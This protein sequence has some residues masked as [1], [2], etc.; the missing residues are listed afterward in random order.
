MQP[1]KKKKKKKKT[2]LPDLFKLL[3]VKTIPY[4]FG[5]IFSFYFI[6]S[7]LF[8]PVYQL[9]KNPSVYTIKLFSSSFSL[10]LKT[11]C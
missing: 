7:I 10:F 8:H 6:Y 2:T 3:V 4:F 9:I 5:P 11:F 1:N